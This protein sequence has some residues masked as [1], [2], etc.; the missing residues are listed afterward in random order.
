MRAAA[1]PAYTLR[2]FRTPSTWGAILVYG[3]AWT[4]GRLLLGMPEFLSPSAEFLVPFLFVTA[5]IALAPLPW[6][7]TRDDHP[8]ARPV[9]GLLQAIPWNLAWISM[10]AWTCLTIGLG[11]DWTRTDGRFHHLLNPTL[12]FFFLNFPLALIL[13]WFLADKER[14]EASGR[15]LKALADQ[16]R[17][18]AL[19]AQLSPHVLFNV[20][21]GLTELVHEDADAAE[22]A[23]VGLT[24]L[25]RQLTTH[26]SALKVPLR[27]ERD[28]IERYLELEEIRLG[29]RLTLEWEWPPWA[30]G[31]EL[32]PLLLQP[33]VENAIKHG[34][35]PDPEGGILRVSVQRD[36]ERLVLAVANTGK[37]LPE[38]RTEGTG[39]GN[40][41][42]RLALLPVLAPV[43]ELDQVG[44]WT[45]AKL[46]LAWRWTA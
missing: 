44:G 17:A 4:V 37:P 29:D 27:A 24:E 7:W 40:L 26:G 23:L 8:M 16:A 45:R 34:I 42:Q 12:G 15:E 39:L 18:Q 5:L 46:T 35:S 30:D 28:L 38:I 1:F 25:Y 22:E 43:L 10:L 32:P 6:L 20:L 3:L 9:R 19:Q 31:L 21:S 14:A 33:L 13:G 2:K 36:Q 11:P 41:R